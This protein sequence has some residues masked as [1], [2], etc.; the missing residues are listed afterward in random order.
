[1]YCIR[2][3]SCAKFEI[4][5]VQLLHRMLDIL[6]VSSFVIDVDRVFHRFDGGFIGQER[7]THQCPDRDKRCTNQ[8][9]L[10]THRGLLVAGL[11]QP[12]CLASCAA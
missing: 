1:M 10:H 5:N 12:G 2:A 7:I 8:S 6:R 3:A 9:F 11:W 4:Q